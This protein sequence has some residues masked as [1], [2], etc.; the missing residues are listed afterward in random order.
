M[1]IKYLLIAIDKIKRKFRITS[2]K[3]KKQL[4]ASC[5]KNVII[6]DNCYLT[7]E[8]VHIGNNVYIGPN[9][10]FLSTKSYIK[11]GDNIMF[12]PNVTIVT[13]SHRT[14]ILGRFMISIKDSEKLLENDQPVVFEGDNWIGANVTILK[15][16]RIGVGS[17]VAAGAVVTKNIPAYSVWG[18]VPASHLKFRFNQDEIK[19]HEELIE[20]EKG[21]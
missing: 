15:G 2:L 7:W 18:G 3:Y 4:L 8:N 11:I 19:K 6:D 21:F 9:A 20:K 10:F 5:G 1:I 12:G 13:G 17:I 16:V 14:D